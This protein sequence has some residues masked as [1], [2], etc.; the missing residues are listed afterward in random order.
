MVI[1]S[2]AVTANALISSHLHLVKQI[3]KKLLTRFTAIFDYS[4]VEKLTN[5]QH[6]PLKYNW[7]NNKNLLI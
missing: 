5:N 1:K 7:L 2:Q 4:Y 6:I 3:K